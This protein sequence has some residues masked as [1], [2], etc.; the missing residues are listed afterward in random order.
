MIQDIV[1]PQKKN[2]TDSRRKLTGM[3]AGTN[4]ARATM[5]QRCHSVAKSIDGDRFTTSAWIPRRPVAAFLLAEQP[6]AVS[7]FPGQC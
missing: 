2:P 6:K 5:L 1:K 3:T 7:A 4:V